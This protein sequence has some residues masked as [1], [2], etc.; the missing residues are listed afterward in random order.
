MMSQIT[1]FYFANQWQISVSQILQIYIS[2]IIHEHR[3]SVTLSFA[4]KRSSDRTIAQIADFHFVSSSFRFANHSKPKLKVKKEDR[5]DLAAETL[6][7]YLN[8][9]LCDIVTSFS[10]NLASFM[11]YHFYELVENCLHELLPFARK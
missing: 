4:P 7:S 2:Q 9:F 1:D 5:F 11:T 6:I 8:L 3:F 10:P